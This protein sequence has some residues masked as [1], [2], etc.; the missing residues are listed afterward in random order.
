MSSYMPKLKKDKFVLGITG[1]IACGK[2]TVASMFRGRDSLLINADQL[3]HK[4]LVTG[5]SAYKKVIRAFGRAILDPGNSINRVKLSKIVFADRRALTRLNRITHP[6]LLGLIKQRIRSTKKRR[7]ILDAPLIVESGLVPL[8]DALVVVTATRQE[9][10]RRA[11]QS[12]G[13]S[14]RQIKQRIKSQ[15]SQKAKTR[16]ADFIIDNSGSIS[17]TKEQVSKIRRQL[18]KS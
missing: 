12:L 8:M 3:G 13:L 15:I 11:R 17:K 10:I 16:F 18:W 7:V 9:Q 5:S 2:S 4:L 14:A 1:S 6:E